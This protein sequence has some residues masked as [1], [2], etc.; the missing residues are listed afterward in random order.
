MLKIIK[1]A[2]IYTPEYLGIKDVLVVDGKIGKIDEKIEI[3]GVEVEVIDGK[4]KKLVPG[5]IDSHVH[6]TGGGGEGGFATR[7]PEITLSD[8]IQGGITTI[9]GTLGT[10]GI[11]RSPENLYAKAKALEEEGINTYIYTGSYRIPPITFTGSI[12]K[13]LILIDKVIGVGEIAISD[14]RS[15]QPTI[16]ELKRIVADARVGGMLSGKSGVV[17]FHVGNGKNGIE[18]LFEI[19]QNT[20]IPINHLYPTHINRNKDLLEQGIEFAKLGGVVDFTTS[21]TSKDPDELKAYNALI[22]YY[23]A[24]LIDKVTFTSD[25]QGSLPIFDE[26]G[27]FVKLGIGKVTS[28]YYEVKLAVLKGLPLE[29][30][31][32]PITVNPAKILGLKNKG[33]L[34]E[35]ANADLVILD[36]SLN[37]DT[38]ISKGKVLMSDK[39]IVTKGI[40]EN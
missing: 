27:N 39:I 34:K 12:M 4:G 1:S 15:S 40:F 38:V 30:A 29:E 14:H 23:E 9:V 37:I 10:D 28:L 22:R 17:N 16:E 32:K 5:F 25:G 2:E 19:V 26:K 33:K 13:D 8:I 20:E 11:T 3:T 31:L 21:S 36:E 35:G 24:G 18:P 7:T 6:L